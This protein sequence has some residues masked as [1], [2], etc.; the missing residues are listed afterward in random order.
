ML[1]DCLPSNFTGADI[2]Q[3]GLILL[4]CTENLK[5]KKNSSSFSV[6]FLFVLESENLRSKT[7]SLG[8][9]VAQTIC[10]NSKIFR[11]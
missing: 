1:V 3:L 2:G 11:F 9:S 4:V 10:L 5:I 8:S 6:L 7:N